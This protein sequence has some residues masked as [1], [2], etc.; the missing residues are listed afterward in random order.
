LQPAL[1]VVG[2]N[3]LVVR[4]IDTSS[5]ASSTC[6]NLCLSFDNLRHNPGVFQDSELLA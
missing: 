6:L 3:M 5:S 2:C 1:R 4:V